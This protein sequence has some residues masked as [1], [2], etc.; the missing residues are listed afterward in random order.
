GGHLLAH[1][2]THTIQQGASPLLRESQAPG[3]QSLEPAMEPPAEFAAGAEPASGGEPASIGEAAPV[4]AGE[5]IPDTRP[6]P[7][8][9]LQLNSEAGESIRLAPQLLEAVRKARSEIGKVDAKKVD[10]DGTR[11]GWQRL[12]E[13]FRIAFG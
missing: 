3:G 7:A 13:Y 1:E 9:P 6:D 2:L 11:H 8:P 10:E 4:G 5:V 12:W